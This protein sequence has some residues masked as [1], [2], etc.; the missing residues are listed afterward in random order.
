MNINV[1]IFGQMISFVLF[2]WFCM[3]YVWLP[4]M[5]MIEKRQKEIYDSLADVKHTKMQSDR[6]HSE[7]LACLN[8]ARTQ[9]QDIISNA[10]AYKLQI[11]HEAKC[12]AEQERDKILLKTREKII[13]EKNCAIAELKQGASNLVIEATE[14]IIEYSMN[15]MIDHNFVNRVLEQLSLEN[16]KG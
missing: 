1:T 12:A 6:M 15:E 14:K 2:V 3:K 16:K 10:N 11:L 5:S 7:A 8:K 13:Y 4:L 9:A